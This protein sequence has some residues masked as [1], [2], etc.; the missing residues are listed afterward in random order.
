VIERRNFSKTQ[1]DQIWQRHGPRFRDVPESVAT[2]VVVLRGIGQ[3]ANS[4]AIQHNPE[5]SSKRRHGQPRWK[6]TAWPFWGKRRATAAAGVANVIS[7]V[8]L[9][10][11]APDY[12]NVF[13]PELGSSILGNR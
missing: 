2:G 12:P 3:R 9:R 4:H 8:L 13:F 10:L 6:Y 1:P 7:D 5:D 11:S